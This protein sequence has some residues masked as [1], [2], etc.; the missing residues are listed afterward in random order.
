M[1]VLM[2]PS[3]V[4]SPVAIIGMWILPTSNLL[5]C[6]FPLG[7]LIPTAVAAVMNYQVNLSKTRLDIHDY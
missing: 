7:L 5:I 3:A 1:D 4:I 2:S 6:I